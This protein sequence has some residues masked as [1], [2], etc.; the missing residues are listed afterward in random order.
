MNEGYSV[1]LEM[2]ENVERRLAGYVGFAEDQL[3]AVNGLIGSTSDRW[4]GT[5][6]DAYQVKHSGWVER[7]ADGI[8]Q[9]EQVRKRL[10]DALEAYK[11]ALDANTQ[12]FS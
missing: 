8:E 3:R 7:A 2:L 1:D 12:M 5:A 9:L 4:K 6:A 10:A 11:A